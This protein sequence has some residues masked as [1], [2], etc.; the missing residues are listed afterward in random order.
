LSIQVEEVLYSAMEDFYVDIIIGQGQASR[1]MRM[2]I[3]PFTLVG[4]TTR[5]SLLSRPLQNRFGIQERLEFYRLDALVEIIKRNCTILEI[6]IDE[7]GALELAKRSRGTPRISNRLLKR[8]WDF[9]AVEGQDKIT[10]QLAA[11][12]LSRLEIDHLG[13]DR[14]DRAILEAIL[15]KHQGGPVGLDT[16]AATIGEERS[17]I[18]E[19]FEPYLVY[20]G[21]LARGPRGRVLTELGRAHLQGK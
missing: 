20:L 12:S 2:D 19:V 1:S 16:L 18:E 5:V 7:G 3:A 11:S 17:T 21:F 8:V 13:L 14:S 15:T 4:A 10:E 9:A 6:E